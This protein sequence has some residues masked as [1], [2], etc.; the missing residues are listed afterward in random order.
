MAKEN[1]TLEQARE[2]RKILENEVADALRAFEEEFGV[3]MLGYEIKIERY[4][5]SNNAYGKI[6][7]VKINC[8]I[9]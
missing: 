3:D 1:V 2:A 7:R 9:G 6:Q 8:Q 4:N 5:G